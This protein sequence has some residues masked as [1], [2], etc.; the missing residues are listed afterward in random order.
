M[1]YP[2]CPFLSF[3]SSSPPYVPS[4]TT[5]PL[6]SCTVTGSMSLFVTQARSNQS[7]VP[8]PRQRKKEEK[9]KSIQSSCEDQQQPASCRENGFLPI[10]G[11]NPNSSS[12]RHWSNIGMPWMPPACCWYADMPPC[13]WYAAGPPMARHWVADGMP[14]VGDVEC[15]QNQRKTPFS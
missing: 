15:S 13:H 10:H 14:R 12:D 6:P 4:P 9:E 7:T 8:L 2:H 11:V 1:D 5:S 3:C